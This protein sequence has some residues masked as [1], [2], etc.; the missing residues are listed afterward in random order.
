MQT[1][2]LVLLISM[3]AFAGSNGNGRGL[4]ELRQMLVGSPVSLSLSQNIQANAYALSKTS[5]QQFFTIV[6]S[7]GSFQDQKPG[8]SEWKAKLLD[9]QNR[10]SSG[11]TWFV[12]GLG[13]GTLLTVV[14]AATL[15]VPLYVIGGLGG[16]VATVYGIVVWVSANDDIDNLKTEG[17]MKGYMSSVTHHSG[18]RLSLAIPL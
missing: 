11:I 4:N 15:S 14:G 2:L 13:G 10:R 1:S 18:P 16:T 3:P 17:Q 6:A 7:D 12:V 9:A 8:E 5:D